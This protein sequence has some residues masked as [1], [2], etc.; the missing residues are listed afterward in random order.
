MATLKVTISEQL[1]L[2]GVDRSSS[3][4]KDVE[5]VSQVDNRIV[6][7]TTTESD[8]I[9]FDSNVASGTFVPASVKY[10]R[11]SNVSDSGFLTLRILGDK[12]EYA[13][14]VNAGDSF[15]INNS[16]MDADEDSAASPYVPMVIS[17]NNISEI[18]A[19]AS[20]STITTEVF[21]AA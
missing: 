2:Q 20:A 19:V 13:V 5:G 16:S 7:V 18:R 1:T 6:S 14:K 9:K 15:I 4:V 11:I 8:I 12:E 17:F 10:I 21:I 3:R